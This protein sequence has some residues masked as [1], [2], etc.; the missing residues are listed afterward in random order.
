M[1]QHLARREYLSRAREFASRGNDRPNA[2][3]DPDKVRLIRSNPEGKTPKQLA[4]DFGVHYRTIEKV[5]YLE[6][7][8]HVE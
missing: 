8:V 3:L 7:W 4:L 1:G 5:I 6:T 2:R